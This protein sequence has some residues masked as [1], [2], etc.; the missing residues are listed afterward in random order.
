M[1][2]LDYCDWNFWRRMPKSQIRNV[3]L[4]YFW[5]FWK[6][7]LD[8]L[9][10]LKK[11]GTFGSMGFFSDKSQFRWFRF[12]F[13]F[14]FR[15]FSGRKTPKFSG[16][17]FWELG[18]NISKL[19]LTSDSY[20]WFVSLFLIHNCYR[21]LLI[22]SIIPPHFSSVVRGVLNNTIFG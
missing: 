15:I 12:I 13:A 16:F 19:P 18:K 20:R 3:N 21:E 14:A 8:I 1:G 22:P 10:T 5:N 11:S 9:Q 7:K 4:E 17:R 6:M 2:F